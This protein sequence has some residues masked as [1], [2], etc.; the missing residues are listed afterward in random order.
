LITPRALEVIRKVPVV[1]GQPEYLHLIKRLINGKLAIFERQSP[2]ER[3]RLTVEKAQ[4]ES[5][6][7]VVSVGDPGTF[8]I[9]STFLGYIKDNDIH[10]HVQVIPGINLA[11]YAASL[12]GAPLGNDSATIT[13]TDQGIPWTVTKQRLAAVAVADFVIVIYNPIGKL[14]PSRLKESLA[15]VAGFRSRETPVGFVSQAAS[16]GEKITLTTI[17]E[18][19][20]VEITADTLVIIGNSQSYVR[21]EN[22]N[23]PRFYQEGTGY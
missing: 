15:L 9:A 3:C 21:E 13:L 23:T 17:E 2:L 14:G 16:P 10:L 20:K 8:A 12:M 4:S 18:S 6:V 22:F 1:I 19:G 5:D 11:G 7:A